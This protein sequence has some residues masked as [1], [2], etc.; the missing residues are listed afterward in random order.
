M[1][2]TIRKKE[3]TRKEKIL[4]FFSSISGGLSFLGG[5]QVCHNLC[6]GIIA[7]LSLIGI[8]VIGMPLLFLTKYT[9]FF[10][11]LA[12]LLLIPTILIYW[13]HRTRMSG[14]IVLFNIGI[15]IAS[16]PFASLQSYNILFW[17]I[18]GVLIGMS[19]LGL[20]KNKLARVRSRQ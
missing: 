17:S 13:K 1:K 2:K 5:W 4:S 18:G 9:I 3:K 14:K 11:S 16:I 15:I 19:I 20:I 8:T 10:W 6:L 12:V 7:V